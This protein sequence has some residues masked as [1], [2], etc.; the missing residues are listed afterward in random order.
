M[1]Q[2]SPEEKKLFF[3]KLQ[4]IFTCLILL[5]V[6]AGVIFLMVKVDS[7]TDL[8]QMLDMG[9]VNGAL[10]SLQ[11]A[12]DVMSEIDT[13]ALNG[14]IEELAAASEKLGDLDFQKITKFMD[15]L[16]DLS[17]QMDRVTGFFKTFMGK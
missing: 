12:A 3:L 16:E 11:E 6:A 2:K 8:A 15:S 13:A 7:I 1:K 4:T 9:K 14:G 10:G 17:V 5:L